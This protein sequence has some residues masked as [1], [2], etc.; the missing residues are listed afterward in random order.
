MTPPTNQI[1]ASG[2][3]INNPALGPSLQNLVSSSDPVA[4]F[5]K[6]LPNLITISLIVGV[7]FFL[8]ELIHSSIQWIL[9]QGEKEHIESARRGITNA[10]IGLIVLFS[11]F[12]VFKALQL[13]FGINLLTIDIGPLK[14]K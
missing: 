10:I 9:S 11:A 2:T 8:Y 3:G 14:I 7:L 12:A 1:A 4:F 6:L 13:F 5:N